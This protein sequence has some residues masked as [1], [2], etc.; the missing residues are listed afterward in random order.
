[1]IREELI[2]LRRQ[3]LL[4]L[5]GY[6]VASLDPAT[7][8]Q[9]EPVQV[10]AAEALHRAAAL[11]LITPHHPSM[12]TIL[13]RELPVLLHGLRSMKA[14]D[15]L[16]ASFLLEFTERLE[17]LQIMATELEAAWP[18]QQQEGSG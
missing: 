14:P 17:G 7:C 5:K 8:V 9:L 11:E 3:A 18:G 6:Y 1:M 10:Q 15:E 12:A 16:T 4:T 13:K 2:A